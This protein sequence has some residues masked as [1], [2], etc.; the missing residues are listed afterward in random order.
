MGGLCSSEWLRVARRRWTGRTGLKA[1]NVGETLSSMKRVTTVCSV[2]PVTVSELPITVSAAAS[3]LSSGG[4]TGAPKRVQVALGH[5]KSS[6]LLSC[7]SSQPFAL[8]RPRD[9]FPM[10]TSTRRHPSVWRRVHDGSVK[11]GP[12]LFRRILNRVASRPRLDEKKK[13]LR[14]IFDEFSMK[15]GHSRPTTPRQGR[16]ADNREK[17]DANEKKKVFCLVLSSPFTVCILIQ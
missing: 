15:S 9:L 4:S 2:M 17:K 7:S 3:P 5:I 14:L 11:K 13:D 12:S 8:L 10:A 6:A 1:S 16:S